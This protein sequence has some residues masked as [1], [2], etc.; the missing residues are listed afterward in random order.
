MPFIKPYLALA[1][2][3]SLLFVLGCSNDAGGN[4]IYFDL[5]ASEKVLPTDF[6]EIAFKRDTT[7]YF[8][9]LV[10]KVV[11]QTEFEKMWNIY[12]FRDKMPN[13]DFNEKGVI[14]IGV[15]ESG[16]CPYKIKSIELNSDNKVITLP[17]SQPN[18]ACTD[19]STPR[20]FVIEINKD[21]SKDL[22]NLE[23][24]QSGTET[25]IPINGN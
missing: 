13:V 20:T 4:Q 16:S 8:Q 3:L 7:P 12:G 23:I 22:E 2:F 11:N 19:D 10:K 6:D 1:V 14:F 17:L 18:G 25:T 5:I 15:Q 21:V 9:Y 24:V